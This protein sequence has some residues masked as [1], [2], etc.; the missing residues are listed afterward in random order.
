VAVPPDNLVGLARVSTDGRDARLEFDA[1]TE[2][3]CG[4]LFEEKVFSGKTGRPGLAAALEYVRRGDTLCVWKLDRLGRSGEDVLA[5]AGDL[6][7]RGV[8]V[9][10]LTGRLA[11]AYRAA[12]EGAFFSAVVAAFAELERGIVRRRAMAGLAAARAQGRR[13][14][15]PTVMDGDRLAAAR[16]RRENGESPAQIAKALGG[17]R[18][19]VYRHLA[20]GGSRPPGP[21]PAPEAASGAARA[22]TGPAG[23]SLASVS[24]PSA[25]QA[26]SCGRRGL[27]LR[28]P[29]RGCSSAGTASW[30]CWRRPRRRPAGRGQPKVVLVEG[31]AGIGKSALLARFASGLAGAAVLRASSDEAEL[32]LPCGMVGQLVASA[33]GVGGGRVGLLASELSDG[34]DPLAVGAELV[35]WLGQVYRRRGMVLAVIDDL[36]W[37]DGP[38]ARALL[39]AVRRLHAD[40]VLVVVAVRAGKRARLQV[41]P[42]QIRVRWRGA[43]DTGRGLHPPSGTNLP[44]GLWPH[45]RR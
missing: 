32:L 2:A 10:V 23:G 34:V 8:G 31:E 43:G 9:R 45:L 25:G 4:R 22:R 13:G 3:G 5:V 33:R 27:L 11:G 1:L 18:A 21:Q 6:H 39:F 35:V 28:L 44:R 16:A 19:S 26:A 7:E 15:R 20:P 29:G 30:P 24:T 42:V 41:R 38:S 40:Q 36:Q 37:A 14:G 17:S 12:G